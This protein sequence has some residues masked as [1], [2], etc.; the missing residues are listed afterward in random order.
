MRRKA[1]TLVEV[2][3]AL[4]V[5][6]IVIVGVTT[7]VIFVTRMEKRSEYFSHFETICLD[8]DKYSDEYGREWDLH[9]YG[10]KKDEGT[11]YYSSSYGIVPT[12]VE[13]K[14]TLTYSYNG[15]NQLIINVVENGKSKKIIDDLNYGGRRYAP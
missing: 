9:Y 2:M 1:F 4:A 15:S 7:T 3:V 12:Q 13:S 6:A 5:F 8:I 14:F 11:I 10:E